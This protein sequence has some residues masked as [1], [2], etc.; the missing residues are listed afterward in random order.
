MV[1]FEF[2]LS[3]EDTDRIFALKKAAGKDDLSGNEYARELLEATLYRM[4]PKRPEFDEMG[5]EI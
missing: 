5:N 2:Y 3:G 4:H 1:K